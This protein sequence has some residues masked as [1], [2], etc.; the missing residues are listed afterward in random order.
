MTPSPLTSVL[1]LLHAHRVSP[2]VL[3]TSRLNLFATRTNS[4]LSCR[5]SVNPFPRERELGL[6]LFFRISFH[7]LY[8]HSISFFSH[9]HSYLV[10]FFHTLVGKFLKIKEKIYF[11]VPFNRFKLYAQKTAD[12]GTVLLARV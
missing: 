9:D 3:C 8:Y 10:G 6:Y 1:D 12:K 4:L 5:P 11:L 7:P 2:F